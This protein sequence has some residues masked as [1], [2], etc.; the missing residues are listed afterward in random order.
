MLDS[1]HQDEECLVLYVYNIKQ[2]WATESGPETKFQGLPDQYSLVLIALLWY[3]YCCYQNV[4][5][6]K[7]WNTPRLED[8]LCSKRFEFKFIYI[9]VYLL[10]QKVKLC[11]HMNNPWIVIQNTLASDYFPNLHI[12]NPKSW[13]LKITK[14]NPKYCNQINETINVMEHIQIVLKFNVLNSVSSI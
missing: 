7:V 12:I 5:R 14:K 9:Y 11:T 10:F 6:V 13:E 1:N 4:R 8:Y 2:I 3:W